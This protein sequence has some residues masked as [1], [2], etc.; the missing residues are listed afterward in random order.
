MKAGRGQRAR[1]QQHA[2]AY[3]AAARYLYA[4]LVCVSSTSIAFLYRWM[5]M[6]RYS[7][8]VSTYPCVER[9]PKDLDTRRMPL[10]IVR[11][12]GVLHGL[13]RCAHWYPTSCTMLAAPEIAFTA[14]SLPPNVWNSAL[15]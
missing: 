1:L 12:R 4:L 6:S 11:T 5:I 2:L 7:R 9:T 8:S 15:V 14:L 13:G 10:Y 3:A